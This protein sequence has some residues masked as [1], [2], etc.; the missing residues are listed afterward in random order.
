MGMKRVFRK[1]KHS[2]LVN[3][4]GPY[5]VVAARIRAAET[6]RCPECEAARALGHE[7]CF[8]PLWGDE[9]H[10]IEADHIRRRVLQQACVLVKCAPEDELPLYD[11]LIRKIRTL[12]DAEWWLDHRDDALV[13]LAHTIQPG[14][15]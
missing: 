1:C 8:V 15:Y 9:K 5:A 14:L 12:S 7:S 11:R 10:A 6:S 13:Y 3:T 4:S 2:T